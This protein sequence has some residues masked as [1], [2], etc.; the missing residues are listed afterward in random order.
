[1]LARELS[2]G[3]WRSRPRAEPLIFAG[4]HLMKDWTVV[5]RLGEITAPTL[6]VAGRDDFVFP[7]ECQRELAAGIPRARLRIIDRAGHNPHDEQ[8]AEVMEAVTDF[9]GGGVPAG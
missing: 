4:R 7:P 1:M 5:D 8:P 9:L 2:S 3:S 6:V